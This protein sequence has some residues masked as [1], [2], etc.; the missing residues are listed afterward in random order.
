MRGCIAGAGA[1]D[2]ARQ[3]SHPGTD[4]C[5]L[6]STHRRAGH[7]AHGRANGGTFHAAVDCRLVGRRAADLAEGVLPAFGIIGTELIEV[8]AGPGHRHDTRSG[9]DGRTRA[10]H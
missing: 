2:T 3:Q 6:T 7:G 9:R 10:E 4:P 5:T 8:L 1:R